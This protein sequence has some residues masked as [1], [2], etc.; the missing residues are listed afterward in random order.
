MLPLKNSFLL[1]KE[2]LDT[3]YEKFQN[4]KI[5]SHGSFFKEVK[6]IFNILK[7]VESKD[8]EN[9][10]KLNQFE[11]LE[12]KLQDSS[13]ILKIKKD[14]VEYTLLNFKNNYG[15]CEYLASL[16]ITREQAEKYF[17]FFLK[18]KFKNFGPYEDAIYKDDFILYHSHCSYLINIGLLTPKYVVDQSLKYAKNN[19]I[20]INSLEGFIRQI[21]GWREFTRY[22]YNFWGR[23]LKNNLVSL[24]GESLDF[25]KWTQGTVGV[26]IIDNEIKKVNDYAYAHHIIRLMVFLNFMKLSNIKPFDIYKWFIQFVSLDAYEWVMV[27]NIGMM[28]YFMK[29]PKFMRRSYVSSSNYIL[30]MSNYKKDNW[31]KIWDDLYRKYVAKH[32]KYS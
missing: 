2:H 17:Q 11:K 14:A 16:P 23:D 6:S 24:P 22:V 10:L 20:P 3:L 28:G 26:D 19:D 13:E 18:K 5:I 15:E 8:K 32:G 12:F 31:S 7:D 30:K 1:Q 9:R 27:S 21:V 4:H 29:T 25:K